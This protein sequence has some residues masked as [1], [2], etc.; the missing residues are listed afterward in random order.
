M[1]KENQQTQC[2]RLSVWQ[3][4]AA[5]FFNPVKSTVA[6]SAYDYGP[7]G[8]ELKRNLMNEWWRSMVHERED[9]VG[10]D[11]S[12]VMHPKVWQASGHLSGF[13]D[14]LVDCLVSKERFRADKAPRPSS[15]WRPLIIRCPDKGLAKAYHAQITERF[16]VTLERKGTELHGLKVIDESTF[17]W[18]ESG[19]EDASKTFPYRGYVSPL[20]GSPFL[21]DERQ[22]NL[23][24]RTQLG[25]VDT[26]GQISS[27]IEAHPELKGRELTAAIDGL[28]KESAVYLRPETAQAMFVQF[29]NVQQ[30]MSMKVPF[31]IAQMGKSFGK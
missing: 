15:G 31:G 20:I 10:L 30:S 3:S 18:F 28:I 6:K 27:F 12:I 23:M 9:V 4:V 8:A 14:P 5:L 7:L 26:I 1:A 16:E 22:F 29:A 11:A 25:A 13:S 24:F 21:S 19:S 2:R 17:G